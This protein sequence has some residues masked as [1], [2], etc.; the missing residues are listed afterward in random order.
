MRVGTKLGPGGFFLLL[1]GLSLVG[2]KCTRS[3]P[4]PPPHSAAQPEAAQVVLTTGSGQEVALKV[5][6]AWTRAQ[7]E[8]GLMFRRELAPDTGMLFIFP[9]ESEHRFWMKNTWIPLDLIF[10]DAKKKVVGII[11]RAAP[12]SL[13]PL[14]VGRPSQYVLE[15]NAGFCAAHGL[16]EGAQARFIG[17]RE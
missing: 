17:I 6:L 9:D 10:L 4:S 1:A 14:T 7:R 3:S 5:E 11:A 15:V 12:E 8:R 16:A 2:L 13:A